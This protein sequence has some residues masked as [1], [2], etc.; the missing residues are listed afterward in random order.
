MVFSQFLPINSLHRL[1]VTRS[2]LQFFDV[3][4]HNMLLPDVSALV[5][6]YQLGQQ[7]LSQAFQIALRLSSLAAQG[8]SQS[9]KSLTACCKFDNPDSWSNSGKWQPIMT[10]LSDKHL[11]CQSIKQGIM[12]RQLMQSQ[13]HISL[14]TTLL[15]KSASLK[16]LGMLIQTLLVNSG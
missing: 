3:S 8:I 5:V 1:A 2:H 9:I 10:S 12:L 16:W 4:L 6:R 11:K 7:W 14:L 13:V 15:F